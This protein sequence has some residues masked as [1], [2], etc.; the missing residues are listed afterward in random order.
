MSYPWGTRKAMADLSIGIRVETGSLDAATYHT[1]TGSFRLFTVTGRI[2]VKQL[3]GE[4]TTV[5]TSVGSPTL[6]FQYAATTPTIAAADMSAASGDIAALA[7]GQRVSLAG[8]AFNTAAAI[9]YAPGISYG[10]V[11]PM[12]IGA[13]GFI[14]YIGILC[15]TAAS[16]TGAV[17][18][19]L[20]YLPMSTGAFAT[21]LVAIV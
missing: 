10:T 7:K 19:S 13:E 8:S 11:A 2:L 5:L 6:K 4:V 1:I 17:N 16:A 18:W 20:H 14:G 21:P 15:E 12:V 9:T 3:Y